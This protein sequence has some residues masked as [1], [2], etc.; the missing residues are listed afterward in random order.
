MS[1]KLFIF[2][3][4]IKKKKKDEKKGGGREKEISELQTSCN[5]TL[6]NKQPKESRRMKLA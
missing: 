6:Q 5:E 2:K 3:L 4:C 1:F